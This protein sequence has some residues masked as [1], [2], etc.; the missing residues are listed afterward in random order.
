LPAG[1]ETI[2][3]L[4]LGDSDDSRAFIGAM[5]RQSVYNVTPPLRE[6][7]T[8]L[9]TP[10]SESTTFWKSKPEDWWLQRFVRQDPNWVYISGHYTGQLFNQSSYKGWKGAFELD[11]T[12]PTSANNVLW[13]YFEADSGA[14]YRLNDR[15]HTL[16]IL[17]CNAIS[18]FAVDATR[19]FQ[20][21]LSGMNRMPV[22]LG[23][24]DTCPT[25]GSDTRRNTAR[26]VELFVEQLATD[27]DHRADPPHIMDS[28]LKA[29]RGWKGPGR[30]LGCL[31]ATGHAF[32]VRPNR[33]DPWNW[34]PLPTP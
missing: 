27:W 30:R 5:A 14:D 22:V 29:G 32:R 26:L 31:D 33:N 9:P 21:M 6:S 28:W 18:E 34:E 12:S 20:N 19:N 16:L 3:V 2:I 4:E 7:Y 10:L 24:A 17:G 23:F 25:R 8:R 13:S 1:A 15:C 11:F